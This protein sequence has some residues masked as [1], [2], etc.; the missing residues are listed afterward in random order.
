MPNIHTTLYLSDKD[1][2]EKYL[3]KKTEILQLM[4]DTVRKELGIEQKR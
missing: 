1:Y 2:K 3:P 4:R